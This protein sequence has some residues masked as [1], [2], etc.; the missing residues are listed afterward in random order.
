MG[1]ALCQPSEV[2]WKST[3]IPLDMQEGEAWR[4]WITCLTEASSG[5]GA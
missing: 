1:P 2:T 3:L 4:G 5:G